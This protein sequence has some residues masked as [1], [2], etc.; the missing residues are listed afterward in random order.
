MNTQITITLLDLLNIAVEK[1]GNTNALI[2]VWTLADDALPGG[3]NH[4]A[5][6]TLDQIKK[7]GF[8][9]PT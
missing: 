6:L 5:P 9:F 1:E 3:R 2:H 4:T 7:L 8:T